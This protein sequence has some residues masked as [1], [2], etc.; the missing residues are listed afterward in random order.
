MIG[1]EFEVCFFEKNQH[2]TTFSASQLADCTSPVVSTN[3]CRRATDSWLEAP[4][5]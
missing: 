4:Q 1:F 5:M 3:C 2:E